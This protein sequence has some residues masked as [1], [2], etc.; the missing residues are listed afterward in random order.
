MRER[1]KSAPIRR[2]LKTAARRKNKDK[3][4][5]SSEEE[6]ETK[7]P[8]TKSKK[9]TR[10]TVLK[11]GNDIVTMVSLVSPAETDT[12]DSVI[13]LPMESLARVEK[14]EITVQ[15]NPTREQGV[16]GTSFVIQKFVSL[17][18][19]SKTGNSTEFLLTEF[20]C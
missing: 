1:I 9:A 5:S 17:R 15:S 8:T 18:K 14:K 19:P 13:N 11:N 6:K 16:K 20:E 2:K 12:E 4:E 10:R 3:G 7:E